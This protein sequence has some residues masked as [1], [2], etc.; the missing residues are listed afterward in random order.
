M[1]GIKLVSARDYAPK[2]SDSDYT[3]GSDVPWL[4][5][6][7]GDN[8]CAVISGDSRMRKKP[9]EMLALYQHGFVVIFFA[10]QC[11]QWNFYHKSALM[12]HWWE[13][14]IAK[15]R[16]APRGTFW[17]IPKG[18]PLVDKELLNTSLGIAKLLRDAPAKQ[19]PKPKAPT[20]KKTSQQATPRTDARQSSMK[21]EG[22]NGG[23]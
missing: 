17:V 4:D 20:R 18:Y 12:L 14:I 6:F 16:E 10:R 23:K 3:K 2:K 19:A 15:I 9:H 8:G 22:K 7:A 5:R 11:A 21:M 13:Q 1:K